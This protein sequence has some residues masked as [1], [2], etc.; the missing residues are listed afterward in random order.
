MWLFVWEGGKVMIS[1]LLEGERAL[2]IRPKHYANVFSGHNEAY[3][4]PGRDS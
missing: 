4:F 2:W 3:I 1:T